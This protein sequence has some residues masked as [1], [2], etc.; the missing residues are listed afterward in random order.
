MDRWLEWTDRTGPWWR[1]RGTGRK[2]GARKPILVQWQV[3]WMESGASVSDSILT[4]TPDRPAFRGRRTL[5]NVC[6]IDRSFAA[7]TSEA[8]VGDQIGDLLIGILAD[9]GRMLPGVIRGH[10]DAGLFYRM[11]CRGHLREVVDLH[12][13][14]VGRR[15]HGREG[16]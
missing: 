13:R 10:R 1:L 2:P 15:G 16:P 12:R 8:D 9:T 7:G 4:W 11:G 6:R 5:F 3:V 14:L